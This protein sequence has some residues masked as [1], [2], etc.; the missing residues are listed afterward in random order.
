MRGLK[1]PPPSAI[2][3][4]IGFKVAAFQTCEKQIQVPFGKLRAGFRLGRHGDLAQDDSVN[5]K[6]LRNPP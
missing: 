5:K 4:P 6:G 1:P 3:S 2:G